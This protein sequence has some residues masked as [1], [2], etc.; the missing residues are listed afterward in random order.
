MERK[1]ITFLLYWTLYSGVFH[2]FI[3]WTEALSVV[4]DIILL[5]LFIKSNSHKNRQ[6]LTSVLNRWIP[7]LCCMFLL[8]GTISMLMN[9]FWIF[10]YVWNLRFYLRA[11]LLFI[12]IWNISCISDLYHYKK[13]MYQA[14]IPNLLFCFYYFF[15]GQ[16]GDSLGGIFAGGNMEMV[17]YIMPVLFLAIADYYCR[18]I[19]LRKFA[20][21]VSSSLLMSFMGEI[22]LLY[23]VIPIF[24]YVGYV[25]YRKFR[26]S[27]VLILIL[28][29]VLF[30]PTMKYMLSFFYADDYVESVFTM[31]QTAAYTSEGSFVLGT[32]NGMNRSTS[33]EKTEQLILTD[34]FHRFFG[35][36]IGA[37][38]ASLVFFSPIGT[39]FRNTFF[40][41]FTPSYL[42]VEVGKVGWWIF[43]GIYILLFLTF[44]KFYSKYKN[45][46]IKYWAGL[47]ILA[48]LMTFIL[49][50]YNNTPVLVYILFYY[51]FAYCIVAIRE[52]LKIKNKHDKCINNRSVL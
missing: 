50:W 35:Y 4:P 34:S 13:I 12:A 27:H 45:R 39:G 8:I 23:I 47:G 51:L 16:G 18:L 3:Y 11:I 20:F 49:I 1:L 17:I 9:G 36:G 19:T 38:S 43:V 48:N 10:A 2:S 26:M 7:I 28:A 25:L 5:I 21:I 33:I 22:K 30:V 37:S 44:V 14:F 15:T 6:P 29:F 32:E 46:V 31:E 40:F 24:C 41:L 42:M 52:E